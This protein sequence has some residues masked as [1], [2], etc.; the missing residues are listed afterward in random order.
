M[1]GKD[2]DVVLDMVLSASSSKPK[3]Y[4]L[5]PQSIKK[6]EKSRARREAKSTRHKRKKERKRRKL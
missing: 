1:T 4:L 3:F 6:F 5:L 2:L